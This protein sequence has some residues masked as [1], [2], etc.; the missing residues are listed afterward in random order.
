[1]SVRNN[2]FVVIL[3]RFGEG[4]RKKEYLCMCSLAFLAQSEKHILL[5][6][7][8]TPA[9]RRPGPAAP[10]RQ[11]EECRLHVP[12]VSHLPM[13]W[14]SNF[15]TCLLWRPKSDSNVALG[16]SR[17]SRAVMK[18]TCLYV[19]GSWIS[20]YMSFKK[21]KTRLLAPSC[22]GLAWEFGIQVA[23]W[24]NAKS[25][26]FGIESVWGQLCPHPSHLPTLLL[27]QGT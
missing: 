25:T 27:G 4:K 6:P 19:M 17:A 18:S 26:G 10:L 24:Y 9:L 8:P 12:C 16:L 5:T 3:V 23:I 21:T 11:L 7:V 20:R 1:M 13:P 22:Q 15:S 14:K 2:L